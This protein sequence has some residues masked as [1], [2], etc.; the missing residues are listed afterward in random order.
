[1]TEREGVAARLETMAQNVAEALA[2]YDAHAAQCGV[3][4]DIETGPWCEPGRVRRAS[5]CAAEANRRGYVRRMARRV[6]F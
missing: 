3:C 4:R 5:W 6:T 2:R 1:M